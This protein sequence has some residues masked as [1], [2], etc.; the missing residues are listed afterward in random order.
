MQGA[1]RQQAKI[2]V[3]DASIHNLRSV[4][5]AAKN[6]ETPAAARKEDKNEG[7]RVRAEKD[8]RDRALENLGRKSNSTRMK[9]MEAK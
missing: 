4:L 3:N 6:G 5:L 1:R 8:K 9:I 7:V 2:V